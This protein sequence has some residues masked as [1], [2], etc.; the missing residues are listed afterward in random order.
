MKRILIISH[1]KIGTKMA[2][3]GIR[4]HYM[5]EVLSDKFDVTVG[6]FDPSYLPDDR[7]KRCYEVRHIDVHAFNK[8]FPDFEVI[9]ALYLTDSMI[10]FCNERQ[11]LMIFD[12]YAPV[13]VENLAQYIF[14]AKPIS[15]QTD[16]EF[17]NSYESY[18]RFFENGDL[19]IY[20]N[21]RQLDY[22]LGYI[23]GAGQIRPSQYRERP[24]FDRFVPG[25]M[26]IDSSTAVKATQSKVVK[27]VI[28]GIGLDDRVLIWTGGVW[29]WFDAVT[30]IKAMG[31]L[32]KKS[33]NIKLLFFGTKHP[34]PSIPKM[35]ELER[36]ET[37]AEELG[38]LGKTVFFQ[39]G[40]VD[41]HDRLSYLAE[42]DLAVYSHKPSI[43][44]EFSHRTRVLDH[45]LAELPTVATSGDF[46][47]DEVIEPERVGLVCLPNN[48]EALARII[49]QALEPDA[50][51]E[52]KERLAKLRKGYDW[53]ETLAPLV[54]FLSS[55]PSKLP[56]VAP[57]SP[58]RQEGLAKRIA[59]RLL[60]A[61]F[62][63]FLRRLLSYA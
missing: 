58:I 59:K 47:A 50:Y 24:M 26:G 53:H 22:W 49:E 1:D 44:T 21:R 10:A 41:Y 56:H 5:A 57:A 29:D 34:N 20:S 4:Y 11:I 36:A 46:F 12:L 19:F 39:S 33:P 6:F 55:N 63:R 42:A 61:P 17:A 27:G 3:P 15:E 28:P 51:K 30:L 23:F 62:R 52:M 60:P 18:K 40:W 13:P 8:H 45:L 37:L 16:R 2:G 35:A 32:S 48:P 54:E 7:L 43:E 31:Q 14:S 9:I 25:A 38:L